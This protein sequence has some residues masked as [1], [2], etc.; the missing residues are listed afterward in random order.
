MPSLL[1]GDAKA[2]LRQPPV[3]INRASVEQCVDRTSIHHDGGAPWHTLW[4][5]LCVRSVLFT[6][7]V[8]LDASSRLR[9]KPRCN[10]HWYSG[11]Q[12]PLRRCHGCPPV[13]LI[14]GHRTE[15]LNKNY[16]PTAP[17]TES[18]YLVRD[19]LGAAVTVGRV[20]NTP[21]VCAPCVQA[22]T[23]HNHRP[24]PC[25]L[26]QISQESPPAGSPSTH[27]LAYSHHEIEV[28]SSA[29]QDLFL[30]PSPY[31]DFSQDARL[32]YHVLFETTYLPPDYHINHYVTRRVNSGP[33][34]TFVAVL[35]AHH[36][37]RLSQLSRTPAVTLLAQISTGVFPRIRNPFVIRR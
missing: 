8:F 6:N 1:T 29:Q 24:G 34:S 20:S 35:T 16:N 9:P 15:I 28:L 12:S 26:P 30:T 11:R 2:P 13:S 5:Q 3:A 36:R 25:R 10:T 21:P 27:S 4:Q 31:A 23:W 17:H 18:T 14:S 37:Q 32:R 7:T 22:R 19:V 33:V